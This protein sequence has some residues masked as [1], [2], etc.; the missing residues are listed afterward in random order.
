MQL[1][2]LKRQLSASEAARVEAADALADSE[3]AI[4]S[5]NRRL[6]E[7]A[8][9]RGRLETQVAALQS[10][11][12]MV[13]ARQED[14]EARLQALLWHQH[15]LSQRNPLQLWIEGQDPSALARDSEYLVYIGRAS[16]RTIE[17]LR[18]RRTELAALEQETRLKRDQLAQIEVTE[19]E[20]RRA[21]QQDQAR[22]R[23]VLSDIGRQ[24]TTQRD[25]IAK[26]ERD[27]KRLGSLIDQLGRVLA[28][29]AR[30]DA[31][32]TRQAAS[33]RPTATARAPGTSPPNVEVPSSAG[34]FGQLKGKLRLPVAGTL[35][36]R[37]GAP[38]RSEEGSSGPTWK[39]VFI[40][41]AAGTDVQAVGP[42]R[43]V[44]ADW[45][46]GFGNLL[47]IDHGDGYLS[48]YGNNESLLRNAGDEV[49]VREVVALVGNT[50][51]N[52]TPGLYFEL[53]FQGRPFDPL[54]WVAA[55]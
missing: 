2:R 27:E 55:R 12:R 3:R 9:T 37:F 43:I 18:E 17:Q 50:G 32:R 14:Q 30:K 4:S 46:R 15:Q 52:E 29:L 28:E 38:R 8:V 25:S 16:E 5:T 11:A 31:E 35:D 22:R 44:F 13:T 23:R 48:V 39:G 7:L 54:S 47:V 10:R 45:L 53:R 6:R 51:G 36:A 41:A 49:A 1:D 26:L 20:S 24:V 19:A 42:G 34:N 33:K 21:L 40:R